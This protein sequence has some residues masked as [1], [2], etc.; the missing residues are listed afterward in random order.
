MKNHWL[1]VIGCPYLALLACCLLAVT[2]SFAQFTITP[3]ITNITCP[4]GTDGSISVAVSGG[5]LPYTYN[6]SPG[7]Q[8]TQS[9]TGLAGGNYSLTLK[10]NGGQ[11]SI[12]SFT[13]TE[14]LPIS[15]DTVSKTPFCTSNGFI[16]LQPSGGTGGYQFLWNTGETIAGVTNIGEGDYSVVVTDANNCTASF[17]YSIKALECF[18]TPRPYFTPNG[19][20]I[21]DTWLINNSQYFSDARLIVFDR[22]GTKVYEHKGVYEQWDGKSY[23]GMPVPDAVYYYFFYQDKDDKQKNAIPGSVTILR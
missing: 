15:D 20:G 8:K 18:V 14:P 3:T 11:D 2:S 4:A 13:I 19:D 10:D 1:C 9:I 23:L 6:W 12:I 7:G 5:T 16:A 22:W 17:S 21:N